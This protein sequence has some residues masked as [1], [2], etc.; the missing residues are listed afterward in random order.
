MDFELENHFDN[1]VA[2]RRR[3]PK[4]RR[5]V[6]NRDRVR[7]KLEVTPTESMGE[8]EQGLRRMKSK[9]RKSN[10]KVL[11]AL[12]S[13]QFFA[14]RNNH[15]KI[16]EQVRKMAIDIDKLTGKLIE[17]RTKPKCQCG[18]R[19]GSRRAKSN[20]R[21]FSGG[22]NVNQIWDKYKVPLLI[23]GALAFF[24]YSPMGKKLIKK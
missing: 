10:K 6:S 23:G 1:F 21:N 14:N 13:A 11:N 20:Y 15:P 4:R 24:L 19:K 3:K 9:K 18:G 12:K 17:E 2:Q 8:I 7:K 16:Y 5:I 22:G